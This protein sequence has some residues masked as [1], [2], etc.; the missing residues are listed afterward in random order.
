MHYRVNVH[1]PIHAALTYDAF[2]AYI[3]ILER[4]SV[5]S[6]VGSWGEML[7]RM[8]LRTHWMAP[9]GL[10]ETWNKG[11]ALMQV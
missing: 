4:Q 1:P 5:G 6:E 11:L 3:G 9:V 7:N 2:Y 10:G 8:L